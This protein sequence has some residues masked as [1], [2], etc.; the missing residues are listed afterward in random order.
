MTKKQ[1]TQT[2]LLVT[3]AIAGLVAGA[4]AKAQ[5]ANNDQVKNMAG[6]L[7][8]GNTMSLNGCPGCGGKTNSVS[9]N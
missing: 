7:A 3:A 6:K 1:K 5:N 9:T 8:W 2:T 4:V